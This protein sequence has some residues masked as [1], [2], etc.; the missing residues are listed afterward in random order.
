MRAIF[1]CCACSLLCLPLLPPRMEVCDRYRVEVLLI[2]FSRN[3]EQAACL[4]HRP[5]LRCILF[6]QNELTRKGITYFQMIQPEYWPMP[7]WIIP[8]PFNWYPRRS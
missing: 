7:W 1:Q 3:L 4:H 6:I 2:D 5:E 8:S